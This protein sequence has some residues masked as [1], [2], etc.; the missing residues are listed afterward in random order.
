MRFFA[1][2]T[3]VLAMMNAVVETIVLPIFAGFSVLYIVFQLFK[4]KASSKLILD[5]RPT[6]VILAN[7]LQAFF[8]DG[9]DTLE[10]NIEL[11]YLKN[12][13]IKGEPA[14]MRALASKLFTE[15]TP[16]GLP[17]N[18]DKLNIL[19]DQLGFNQF[20]NQEI[21]SGTTAQ[22]THALMYAIHIK[23][24]ELLPV[25][26]QLLPHQTGE[27][28]FQTLKTTFLLNDL[29]TSA[30]EC[31]TESL[32]TNEIIKLIAL[33]NGATQNIEKI[34]LSGLESTS[35]ERIH[36]S[37]L[38]IKHYQIDIDFRILQPLGFHT[39]K[40]IGAIA[41]DLLNSHLI[42]NQAADK[43]QKIR[44]SLILNQSNTSNITKANEL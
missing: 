14:V 19:I 15:N 20:I 13:V 35:E 3:L 24:L 34:I 21:V 1:F 41:M 12:K 25:L 9:W 39:N 26:K 16:Y 43:L 7:F 11:E 17:G 44:K 33:Y 29:E 37:L 23:S 5:K 4:R 31:I 27:L 32:N 2:F 28:R 6:Q 40:K 30:L 8:S 38:L 18:R 22:K 42:E 36:F 10:T